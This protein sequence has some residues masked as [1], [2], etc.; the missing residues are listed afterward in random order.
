MAK[1]N[2]LTS[3][4]FKG[5]KLRRLYFGRENGPAKNRPISVSQDGFL[6]DDRNQLTKSSDFIVGP[7]WLCGRDQCGTP[8]HSVT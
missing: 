8:L 1:C 7:T 6:S 4:P 2:Q 3:L 5:L